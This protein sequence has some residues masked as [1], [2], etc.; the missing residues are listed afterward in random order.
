MCDMIA[1]NAQELFG[2]VNEPDRGSA[3]CALLELG[4]GLGRAGMMAAK[5]MEAEGNGGTVVLT[6]GEDEVVSMLCKNCCINGLVNRSATSSVHEGYDSM[7]VICQQL[8]W[9]DTESVSKLISAHPSGFD[10]II[11]DGN[12]FIYCLSSMSISAVNFRC[13][14]YIWPTGKSKPCCINVYCKYSFGQEGSYRMYFL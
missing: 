11:G 3:K 1:A 2:S 14:P 4:S 5:I 12:G 10:I 8:W 7:S 6:D 9:G 13:R